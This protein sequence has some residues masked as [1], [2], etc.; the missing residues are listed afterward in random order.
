M[1][2]TLHNQP[3]PDI[4]DE[5]GSLN[6]LAKDVEKRL[7]IL[8]EE[9]LAREVEVLPGY[10]YTITIARTQRATIDKDK[11]VTEMG[12]EWW[13]ARTKSSDVATITSRKQSKAEAA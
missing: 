12:Q 11:V 9:I 13:D 2:R 3:G 6:E 7:K 1:A 4:A 10:E 8:R 5:Y